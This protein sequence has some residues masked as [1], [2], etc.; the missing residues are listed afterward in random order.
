MPASVFDF[1]VIAQP[2]MPPPP[3]VQ[4]PGMAKPAE[5]RHNDARGESR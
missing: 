2:A 1:D 5:P 3:P 4:A